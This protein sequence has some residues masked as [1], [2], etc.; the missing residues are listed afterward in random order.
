MTVKSVAIANVSDATSVRSASLTDQVVTAAMKI[1]LARHKRPMKTQ[2]IRRRGSRMNL[3]AG[4]EAGA[5]RKLRVVRIA[6]CYTQFDDQGRRRDTFNGRSVRCA[7]AS[8]EDQS[9]TVP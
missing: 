1:A 2:R 3:R 8:R 7:G 6:I 5:S 4:S 9:W